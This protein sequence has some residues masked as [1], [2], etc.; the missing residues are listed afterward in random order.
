[1]GEKLEK[2]E[3]AVRE[4]LL[5]SA[6]ELFTKKGYAATSVREIVAAAGVTKPVLYYYF[7]SKEGMYLELM[8]GT[9]A[10]FQEVV[11]GTF[12]APGGPRERILHFATTLI[13]RVVE[14]VDLVRLIYSIFFGPPQGA[15][16]FPYEQYFE[17]MLQIVDDLLHEGVETGVF[18]PMDTGR[19]TWIIVSCINTVLEEQLGQTPPRVDRDSLDRMIATILDGIGSGGKK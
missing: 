1:M 16:Y 5:A 18:Q 11:S 12:A 4:R 17:N 9:H 2:N 7:G 14:N 13:D 10:T 19:T 6:L 15:P 3:P 8:Q